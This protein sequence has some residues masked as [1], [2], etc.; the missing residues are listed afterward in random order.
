MSSRW[1]YT[2]TVDASGQ[3]EQ[4]FNFQIIIPVD[5]I[6]RR[7]QH[8]LQEEGFILQENRER[9]LVVL[10][11]LHKSWYF[12]PIMNWSEIRSCVNSTEQTEQ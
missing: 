4:T 7:M 3:S 12:P 11:N 8:N 9:N 6:I 1:V 5:D 10:S 2:G